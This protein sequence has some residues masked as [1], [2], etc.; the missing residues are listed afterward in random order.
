MNLIIENVRQIL[1]SKNKGKKFLSGKEQRN[2]GLIENSSIYIENG[3]IR[4]LAK[5]IPSDFINKSSKKIDG[6]NKVVMPGFIDSHTH[7][8]FAGD[9]A[10]EYS[11]RLEGKTYEDIAKAGGGIINTV[12]AV[13]KA[14]IEDLKKNGLKSIQRFIEYGVTTIEAKSGYGLDTKNEL[15]ML[16]AINEL[17][18]ESTIDIFPTFLGAHAIPPDM[19]KKDYIDLILYEMIPLVAKYNLAK[20]IDVF[21]E[22]KYFTPEE[23][24][25]ILKQGI[26]FG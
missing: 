26:K 5:K 23:T 21:C 4:Y 6:K 22:K 25:T 12:K 10:N 11:M 3:L 15:K 9:R 19:N 8:V 24:D 20:F 16:R 18:D 14:S 7:L 2:I 17:N 1:T 13:R